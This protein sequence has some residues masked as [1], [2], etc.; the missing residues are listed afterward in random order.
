MLAAINR[1][2]GK[3]RASSA[4]DMLPPE[5]QSVVCTA[6]VLERNGKDENTPRVL[7]MT[8]RGSFYRD[9]SHPRRWLAS[10]WPEL[11]EAQILRALGLIDMQVLEAQREQ[12]T[13]GNALSW[14]TWRPKHSAA[15]W[16]A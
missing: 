4:V 6:T 13:R 1:L 15:D 5:L 14:S 12:V 7:L 3:S 8:S 9:E 10:N 16:G 2:F 11:N